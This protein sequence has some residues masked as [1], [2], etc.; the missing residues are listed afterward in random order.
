MHKLIELFNFIF[1]IISYFFSKIISFLTRG[2]LKPKFFNK[3][4]NNGSITKFDIIDLSYRNLAAKKNRTLITIG[5]ITLGIAIIVF[6]VCIFFD[7]TVYIFS[8]F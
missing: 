6:L 5:G 8:C 1:L 3:T 7:Q 4:S 2:K